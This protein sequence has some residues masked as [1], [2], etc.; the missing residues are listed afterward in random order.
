[1]SYFFKSKKDKQ[2]KLEQLVD[3]LISVNYKVSN[4]NRGGCGAFA[5][6]LYDNLIKLGYKPKIAVLVHSLEKFEESIGLLD[7]GF[8][9][10][11]LYRTEGTPHIVVKVGRKYIDST[12]FNTLKELREMY[13]AQEIYE[14]FDIETLRV[15]NSHREGWNTRF[16]RRKIP[17]IKKHIE[18]VSKKV[19]KSL[20]VSK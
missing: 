19:Q 3:G 9:H 12:G 20:E 14:G 10:Y 11:M 18:T 5:E 15:L 1:M 7:I 13:V 8:N 6:H 16:D 4:I 2:T 17:T